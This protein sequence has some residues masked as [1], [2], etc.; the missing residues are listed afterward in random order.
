MCTIGNWHRG[1][2][3]GRQR[4]KGRESEKKVG[5]KGDRSRE[6]EKQVISSVEQHKATRMQ[7]L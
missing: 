4:R 5:E 2:G 3:E 7:Y 6:R 1:E